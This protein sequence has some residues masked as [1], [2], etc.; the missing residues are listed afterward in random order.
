M[1]RVCSRFAKNVTG[2]GLKI[3]K[4][5]KRY[6]SVMGWGKGGVKNVGKDP[7]HV[8]EMN[9]SYVLDRNA[10]FTATMQ[11]VPL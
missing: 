8:T 6:D 9:G 11:N 2:V 3:R 10:C 5:I 1:W 4:I 7:Y